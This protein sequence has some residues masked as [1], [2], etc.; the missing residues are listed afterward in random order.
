M[1]I[2]KFILAFVAI[3]LIALLAATR[4]F[5][6]PQN[7][8]IKPLSDLEPPSQGEFVASKNSDVYHYKDSYYAQRILPGNR[9]WFETAEEAEKAGYRKSLKG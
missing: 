6:C 3:L 7:P 1:I 9:V 4:P 5:D 2:M 8:E